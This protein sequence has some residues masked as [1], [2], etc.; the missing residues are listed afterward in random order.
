MKA[1]AT[2]KKDLDFNK[3]LSSLLN[4]MKDIA[5]S[6]YKV[7]EQKIKFYDELFSAIDTFFEIID[8]KRTAHPFT[9]P[10]NKPQAVIAVTSDNGLIGGLNMQ[11]I[12]TA[13]AELGKIPGKIIA[14]G[15]R[16]KIFAHESGLPY[17]AFGGIQEEERYGQAMQ[18]RDYI[19]SEVLKGS[20]GHVKVVYP[21]PVSFT[22]QRIEIVTFLPFAPANPPKITPKDMNNVIIESGL[23]DIIEYLVYMW[24]GRKLYDIFGLSRL[25][26]FA[27]RFAHLEDSSQKLKDTDKKLQLEYFRVKHELVDRNM[28]EIFAA[29][30]LFQKS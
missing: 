2:L 11:V 12:N 4:T 24:M 17:A 23:G 21:R 3:E 25:S 27:A 20:F 15:E 7:L 6:Q 14:I 28:R 5:V 16:G 30:L 18:L 26:E 9:D 8:A 10:G 19:L 22:M 29:R 1:I 13:I